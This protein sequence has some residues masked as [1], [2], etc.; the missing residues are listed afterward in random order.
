MKKGQLG[1]IEFKY[2]IVGLFIGLIAIIIVVGL[3]SSGVIPFK[4]PLVCG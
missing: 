2:F 4:V 1:I 3:G